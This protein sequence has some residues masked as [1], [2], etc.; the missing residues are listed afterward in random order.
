MSFPAAPLYTDIGA[1]PVE[2]AAYWLKTNDDVRIRMGVWAPEARKGTVMI[3]CGRT[4]YVEKYGI[5]AGDLVA[6]GYAAVAIDWRGQGL[7]D[8]LLDDRNV[9]H[10]I[11]FPDYQRDVNAVVNGLRALGLPE[12]YYLIGHSMG[13][14]IG[15]RALYEALPVTA[16]AF[17]GP[18]WGIS[19][20]PYLRPIAWL[21]GRVMPAVGRGHTLPPGTVT[22]PY[23]FAAPFDDNMLTR[24]R[25][26]WDMMHDQLK[27]HPDLSLG[28]PSYTWL[29]EALIETL[30][31]SERPAPD[32]PCITFLG[33]NERIVHTRRV[34][35]R[36]ADWTKGELHMIENGEHEVMMEGPA[37]RDRLFDT[38]TAFFAKAG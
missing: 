14:C 30:A 28:G 7:A 2:G 19:M 17:T 20:S 10:V 5:P 3:F 23:V 12:P 13:G 31:L 18:M 26:M 16:A 21:L 27:A 38:M 4:E 36:M 15:L 9:G 22:D 33:T 35:Q 1:G 34:H 8:R 6:R 37:M 29:R 32:M 24:D 11:A 25:E